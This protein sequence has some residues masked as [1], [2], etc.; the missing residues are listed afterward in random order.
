MHLYFQN[1]RLTGI[2]SHMHTDEPSFFI[3]LLDTLAPYDNESES[4]ARQNVLDKMR[5]RSRVQTSLGEGMVKRGVISG[6][7]GPLSWGIREICVIW[8]IV[9]YTTT[10]TS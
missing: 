8:N 7:D 5:S 3:V 1:N 6:T 9:I 4:D 10:T 2:S